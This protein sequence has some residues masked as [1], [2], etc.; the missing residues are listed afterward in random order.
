MRQ[1]YDPMDRV[2]LTI[3]AICGPS[4]AATVICE[5]CTSAL[6]RWRHDSPSPRHHAQ[7]HINVRRSDEESGNPLNKHVSREAKV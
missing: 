2:E 4:C 7:H 1:L 5:R 3:R 6:R